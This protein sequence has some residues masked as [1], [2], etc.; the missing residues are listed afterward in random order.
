MIV[1]TSGKHSDLAGLA[2]QLAREEGFTYVE[3]GNQN[4]N[5]LAAAIGDAGVIVVGSNG[6]IWH[7]HGE[8]LFFHPGMAVI[9][10]KELRAGKT[11]QMVAAM[12]LHPGDHVLD[13]TLGLGS[14]A[15]IA[16]VVA[17]PAGKV[18]GLES[19]TVIAGVIR[20]GMAAFNH[21]DQELQAAVQRIKVI[22]AEHRQFLQELPDQSIDIVYFDPMFRRPGKKSASMEPLR[23]VAR[24]DPLT[25]ETILEATRVARRRVVVKEARDSTEF[26]RLGFKEISGGRYSPVA[27]GIIR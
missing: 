4:L 5:A 13:C 20:A 12:D 7:C 14:D 6:I 22:R 16:S 2:R 19:S 11:D 15:V 25:S 23:R 3:R 21:F 27:Y 26:S 1:T 18:I 24:T 9:R 17:G 10:L 8:R